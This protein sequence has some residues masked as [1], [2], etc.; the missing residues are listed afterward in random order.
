MTYMN[1]WVGLRLLIHC[2]TDDTPICFSFPSFGAV[3]LCGMVVV[4]TREAR[5]RS[6]DLGFRISSILVSSLIASAYLLNSMSGLAN[7]Q[8]LQSFLVLVNSPYRL[9]SSAAVG[10]RTSDLM[11]SILRHWLGRSGLPTTGEVLLFDMCFLPNKF[12]RINLEKFRTL[13][14]VRF[15]GWFVQCQHGLEYCSI[16]LP[17]FQN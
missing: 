12:H 1:F 6:V 7:W 10:I 14:R 4:G 5:A 13:N 8:Y 15:T 16:V 2:F 3:F 9:R 17:K 11:C